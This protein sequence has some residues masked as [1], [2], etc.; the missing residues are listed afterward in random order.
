[1]GVDDGNDIYASFMNGT[2]NSTPIGENGLHRSLMTIL[3]I[4]YFV[5]Y[6]FVLYYIIITNNKVTY[7]ASDL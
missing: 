3:I 7:S 2:T 6:S 5:L 1:M 4:Y